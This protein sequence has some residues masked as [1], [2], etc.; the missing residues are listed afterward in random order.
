MYRARKEASKEL[1]ISNEKKQTHTRYI[2]N[3][4]PIVLSSHKKVYTKILNEFKTNNK[5]T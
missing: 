1:K 3:N 2:S 4:E 5:N